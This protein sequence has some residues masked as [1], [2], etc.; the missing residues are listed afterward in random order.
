MLERGEGLVLEAQGTPK[1]ELSDLMV[2][3]LSRFMEEEADTDGIKE[4]KIRE[5]NRI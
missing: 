5:E 3:V 2:L 4:G 1:S